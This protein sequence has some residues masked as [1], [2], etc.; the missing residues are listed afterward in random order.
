MNMKYKTNRKLKDGLLKNHTLPKS[1][2]DNVMVYI[3]V[4]S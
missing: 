3:I 2:I 4:N 1:V